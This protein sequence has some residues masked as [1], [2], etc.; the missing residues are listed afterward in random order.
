MFLFVK[1][2]L[3]HGSKIRNIQKVIK[4][5]KISGKCDIL[6]VEGK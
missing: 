5:G 6:T 1:N 3:S 4:V 2:R